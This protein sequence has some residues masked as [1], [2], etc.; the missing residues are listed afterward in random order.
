VKDSDEQSDTQPQALTT[1]TDRARIY[2]L[3]HSISMRA[4]L[5]ACA[6]GLVVSSFASAAQRTADPRPTLS[7]STPAPPRLVVA[8]AKTPSATPEAAPREPNSGPTPSYQELIAQLGVESASVRE[9]A[10]SILASDSSFTL[11][12]LEETLKTAT[13]TA[14]QRYRLLEA[15]KQRFMGTTRAAMG[16]QQFSRAVVPER[17][18][19][20]VTYPQFPSFKVLQE[21]DMIL[22]AEGEKLRSRDAWNRLGAH[23]VSHEPGE[24]MTVVVRRGEEKLTLQVPLGSYKDLPGPNPMDIAKLERGWQIRAEGLNQ[25]QPRE[26]ISVAI[27]TAK[28]DAGADSSD[29]LKRMR[30]KMQLPAIYRPRLV[31]GGD[32]RGG[33]LDYQEVWDA[34]NNNNNRA[35]AIDQRLLRNMAQAGMVQVEFG[36]TTMTVAQEI[37]E[38]ERTRDQIKA[39]MQ[40]DVLPG[41]KPRNQ[42]LAEMELGMMDRRKTL[43]VVEQALKALHAEA[44]E[45]TD[46]AKPT[47]EAPQP[48]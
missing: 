18:V 46:T 38:L 30:I 41:N 17:V 21:G 37:A 5:L 39:V 8:P 44:S 35:G 34:F 33:E 32:A 40:Q 29:D 22:E 20:G 6:A 45:M 47:A 23:I 7:K 4:C 36:G 13:L 26:P 27:P 1:T 48:K 24:S 19:I 28:W 12:Q 3:S 9:S 14:E 31:A 43:I 2:R 15:S 42:G 16:V 25:H 11:Q 10:L